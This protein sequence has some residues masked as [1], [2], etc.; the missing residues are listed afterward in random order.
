I[1]HL[2]T[3]T[4]MLG[5]DW[6][7]RQQILLQKQLGSAVDTEVGRKAMDALKTYQQQKEVISEQVDVLDTVRDSFA[8]AFKSA[9]DG[10]KSLK[11]A[12]KGMLNS[13]ESKILDIISQNFAESLFGKSGS[14][15]GGILGNIMSGIFGPSGSSGGSGG[16]WWSSIVGAF[17]SGKAAG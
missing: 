15:N 14:S 8:D 13:I 10:T 6:D 12:F 2:K 4:E 3:Q 11:D 16:S 7:Q 1:V 17:S 9:V 5:K